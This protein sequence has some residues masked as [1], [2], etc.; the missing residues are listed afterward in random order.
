RYLAEVN[1]GYNGSEQ[2]APT[3]RFGFF[4]AVS[5]GWVLSN[6]KFLSGNPYITNLKLRTSYGKVGNDK[7]GGYRFLYLDDIQVGGG[8]L[9]SLGG[10]INLTLLANPNIGWEVATKHN[11]GIDLQLMHDLDITF[12]YF[13]EH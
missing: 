3:R 6:E 10:G 2:F 5:L 4:P 9:G 11:Y 8:P 1:L 12:D 7:M 13:T